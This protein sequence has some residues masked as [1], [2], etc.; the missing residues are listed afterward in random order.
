MITIIITKPHVL[1]LLRRWLCQ[2]SQQR[3]SEE[4]S[5]RRRR[6]RT[7]VFAELSIY[8]TIAVIL[9]LTIYPLK[10]LLWQFLVETHTIFFDEAKVVKSEKFRL[11]LELAMNFVSFPPYLLLFLKRFRPPAFDLGLA[12]RLTILRLWMFVSWCDNRK[13]I[14]ARSLGDGISLALAR[15]I[16]GLG[17]GYA[18]IFMTYACVMGFQVGL[19]LLVNFSIIYNF[20]MIALDI[21]DSFS[22]ARKQQLVDHLEKCKGKLAKIP[23]MVPM[24]GGFSDAFN[25][26]IRLEM[27]KSRLRRI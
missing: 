7:R 4:V 9:L 14:S 22:T 16:V 23:Y 13:L 20:G 12:K 21:Y 10:F 5:Q 17:L 8:L 3:S 15:L 18:C 26:F 24:I 6:L 11:Y 19:L 27:A 2:M 1:L 25:S